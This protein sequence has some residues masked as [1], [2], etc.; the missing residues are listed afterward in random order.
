MELKSA[1]GEACLPPD[2]GILLMVCHS[3]ES[4]SHHGYVMA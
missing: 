1:G 4:H 3:I 2:K